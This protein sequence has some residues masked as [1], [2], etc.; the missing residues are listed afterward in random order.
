[1]FYYGQMRWDLK[2]MSFHE[3]WLA[4]SEEARAAIKTLEDNL[5]QHLYKVVGEQYVIVIGNIPSGEEF[6]RTA[7]GRLPMHEHL[8]FDP[9][10]SLEEGFTADV[11]GYLNSRYPQQLQNPKVLY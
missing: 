4:E 6:D 1:M 3:L 2:G 10:W 8:I 7:M 5:V 11:Q 9:V